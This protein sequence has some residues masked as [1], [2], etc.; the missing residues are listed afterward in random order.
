MYGPFE[1]QAPFNA[2]CGREEIEA[3]REAGELLLAYQGRVRPDAQEVTVP[4]YAGD[5][6]TIEL[7]R[8]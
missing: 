8:R 2:L 4:D 5:P 6:R 3:L 1:A 7:N